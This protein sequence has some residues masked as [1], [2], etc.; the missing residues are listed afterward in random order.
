MTTRNELRAAT[1]CGSHCASTLRDAPRP[2]ARLHAGLLVATAVTISVIG[3]HGSD[4]VAQQPAATAPAP[5]AANQVEKPDAAQSPANNATAASNGTLLSLSQIESLLQAQ[6]IRVHE[7]EV[8]DRVVEAEGRD[9]NN[10]KVE[11]IVDRRSG[12]ILSNRRDD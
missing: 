7:L 6:G 11:V 12:E 9:A 8:R 5:A 3:M 1:T 2:A 10:R 4:A